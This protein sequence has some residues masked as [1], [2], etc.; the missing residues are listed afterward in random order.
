MANTTAG[1][2]ITLSHGGNG[3]RDSDG[4][5]SWRH[6]FSSRAHAMAGFSQ[7][8]QDLAL[9]ATIDEQDLS[10]INLDGTGTKALTNLVGFI[11]YEWVSGTGTVLIEP[12]DTNGAT[13]HQTVLIGNTSGSV[14]FAVQPMTTG[15]LV[16][17]S[18]KTLDHTVTG[19]IVYSMTIYAGS[20]T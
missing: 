3:T 6:A 7:F 1:M 20:S 8:D 10:A 18:L 4:N 13:W 12:G 2:S 14:R 17:S 19:T 16:T 5:T 15:A 11:V 9:S